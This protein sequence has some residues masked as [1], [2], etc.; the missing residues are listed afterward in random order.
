MKFNLIKGNTS[1][2]MNASSR[3]ASPISGFPGAN[4]SETSYKMTGAE[5]DAIRKSFRSLPGI[6]PVTADALAEEAMNVNPHWRATDSAPKY[7]GS[8]PGSSFISGVT[9]SPAIGT[10]SLFMTDKKGVTRGP[11]SYNIGADKAAELINAD[12]IGRYYNANIKLKRSGPGSGTIV[13]QLM[14]PESVGESVALTMN[15]SPR[16]PP[17]V[18]G[19]FARLGGGGALGA[20]GLMLLAQLLRDEEESKE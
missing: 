20:A 6:D 4:Y 18:R 11:Y 13:K 2:Y 8:T 12:S 5:E 16:V 14:E 1:P 17:K 19:A 15:S 9:V 7:G 10:V 3:R